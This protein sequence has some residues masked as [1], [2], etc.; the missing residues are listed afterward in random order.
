MTIDIDIMES[1]YGY[2][3]ISW[4]IMNSGVGALASNVEL[5]KN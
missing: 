2:S 3:S 5:A 4:V 1:T